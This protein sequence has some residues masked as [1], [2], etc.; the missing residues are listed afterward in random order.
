MKKTLILAIICLFALS[1]CGNKVEIEDFTK[2]FKDAG[3]NVNGEKEMTREDYGTAPMKAEKGIIFGV[4]KGEDGQ[5][6][7]GRLLEFKN[8]KDLDQTKEYYD[9][10]GK[11]S[12]ILYSHTYKAEDGKY[13]LQMNGEIDDSTFDKYKDTMIKVLNGEKVEKL[14][15]NKKSKEVSNNTEEF[16]SPNVVD[17]SVS[18]SLAD[19]S[20]QQVNTVENT[21]QKQ[22]EQQIPVNNSSQSNSEQLP[23]NGIGGHPS[24]Y[25]PSIPPPSEDNLKT[26]ENGDVYYD[27]T[28]E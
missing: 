12:A 27:A 15:I 23:T 9:K 4:E 21:Q 25:D 3:L 20:P 14:A 1:A 8:E 7:N 28:N 16:Q 24:L 26:D 18:E 6:M 11:E 22:Q 17:S 13:L 5:Y 2:G 19:T 10:L